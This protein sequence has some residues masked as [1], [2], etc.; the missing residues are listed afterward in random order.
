MENRSFRKSLAIAV[1]A[2]FLGVSVIPSV[3]GDNPSFGNTIYV[4]DDNTEGPWDGTQE[5]P[6][7]YIQD[8]IDNA[9]DGDTVFVYNG[10]Y[11]ENVI[12]EKSLSFLG[13]NKNTTI[14]EGQESG[15][16]INIVADG[17]T[18]RNFTLQNC[19]QN[20]G[21]RIF[22]N[23]IYLTD[24]IIQGNKHGISA[25]S[26]DIRLRNVRIENNTIVN[27]GNEYPKKGIEIYPSEKIVIANNVIRNSG[28]H[29]I[30]IKG[31]GADRISNNIIEGGTIGL[32]CD[33]LGLESD[34]HKNISSN[35]F[36]D[37]EASAIE[38]YDGLNFVNKNYIINCGKGIVLKSNHNRVFMNTFQ[39]INNVVISYGDDSS[40]NKI[41]EN[42][43][44]DVNN[45]IKYEHTTPEYFNSYE[46]NYWNRPRI[47]PMVI[48]EPHIFWIRLPSSRWP[49][50]GFGIPFV[51]PTFD[52]IPAKKPNDIPMPEV[53]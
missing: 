11:Y 43:F 48:L 21:V 2:L 10:T 14:I 35:Y 38:C 9:S 27:N 8:A 29:S 44:V 41:N 25:G 36:F 18:I 16:S 1:V 15:N 19:Y 28:Y 50:P 4:D 7:Q 31:S 26:L 53:P 52:I 17:V 33:S 23:N 42:N 30:F 47:L 3:V 20:S 22:S 6:Y 51:L 24:C 40:Y 34:S 13:E 39:D 37:I 12:I 46:H 45:F 5:H 49:D 32:K